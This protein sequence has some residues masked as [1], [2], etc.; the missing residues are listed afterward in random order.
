MTTTDASANALP[1]SD[2]LIP[3]GEFLAEEIEA[4]G[5]TPPDLAD[6]TGR[7]LRFVEDVVRGAEA[8]TPAVARDL[9]SALGISAGF[10]ERLERDYRLAL[11]DE[12][13]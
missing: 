2:L 13:R 3:P 4:R 5:M 9:E 7:T 10:W 6:R 12:G 1:S 11:A 8:I